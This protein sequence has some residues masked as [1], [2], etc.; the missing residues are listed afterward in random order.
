MFLQVKN[1]VCSRCIS[2]VHDLMQ[3]L[4]LHPDKVELGGVELPDSL[5]T[6]ENISRLDAGLRLIGFE[7][8]SDPEE[9]IV[10]SVKKSI[11]E[12]VRVDEGSPLKLS[13]YL[14]N[15][16][17]LDYQSLSRIFSMKEG[18]T[19]EKYH[20]A[21]KVERVKELLELPGMTLAE[22][23]FRTGYSS[24]AHL[25]RQFKQVTGLTVTAYK[26]GHA[27]RIPLDKV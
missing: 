5:A 18:R 8:V 16:T 14:E 12:Y 4:G 2:A 22:I 1:M 23:A 15:A 10:E 17:G 9:R 6:P 7:L 24:V 3:R 11:I 21:Q 27:T 13:A 19:V 20:I 25:S 26:S